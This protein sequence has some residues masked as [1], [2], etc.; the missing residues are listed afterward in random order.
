MG[1]LILSSCDFGHPES[2]KTILENLTK[3]LGDCRVLFFPNEKASPEKIHSGKYHNRLAEYGFARENIAVFDY[4]APIFPQTDVIYISGGNTFLTIDRI[5]RARADRWIAESVKN[6]TVYIGG[7]AGAHIVTADLTHVRKF[8]DPH[9]VTDMRGLGLF[10]GILFCHM[11]PER[12]M[13]A[14][15]ARTAGEYAVVA[16]TDAQSLVAEV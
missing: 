15:Q 6:G 7:S 5:R 12:E 11:T 13:L 14:E 1:R 9:G 8:D 16:L 4:D 10:P 2:V 3:P